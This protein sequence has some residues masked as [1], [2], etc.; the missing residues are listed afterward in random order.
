[1]EHF[2]KYKYIVLCI[3][4]ALFMQSCNWVKGKMGMPTSEDIE[5]MKIELQIKEQERLQREVEAQRVQ[6]SIKNAQMVKAPVL[7]GYYVVLG[8]FKDYRNAE[9]LDALLKKNGYSSQ[10]VML[11]NGFKMVVTGNYSSFGAAVKEMERIG[12]MDFCPY[13]MWI[14]AASQQ[15]HTEE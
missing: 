12:E 6:D 9:A 5:K 15:L 13:D 1:M 14:Y 10:Q 11:K 2:V 7:E 4:A 3:C 8:S